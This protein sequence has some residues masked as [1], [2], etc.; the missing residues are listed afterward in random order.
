[1]AGSWLLTSVMAI[2]GLHLTEKHH[3][4]SASYAA[5]CLL[6]FLLAFYGGATQHRDARNDATR[7]AAV[8]SGIEKIE[9]SVKPPQGATPD[10][11]LA[12]AAAK[13]LQLQK[14]QSDA[15]ALL[16]KQ[17]QELAD[18][19]SRQDW[20]R[21]DSG[22]TESLASTLRATEPRPVAIRW[23]PN[24]A[25]AEALAAQLSSVFKDARWPVTDF[26]SLGIVIGGTS[27]IVGV[28]LQ[29][30]TDPTMERIAVAFVTILTRAHIAIRSPI[31]E[32]DNLPTSVRL[33]IGTKP[34]NPEAAEFEHIH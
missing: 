1:V 21:L 5:V 28:K 26:R 17:N 19:R 10:Q 23:A 13:L 16:S 29:I 18:L 30:K 24:D 31:E 3:V 6:V 4:R 8:Q 12:A 33:L 32:I 11:I 2:H 14:D 9:T 20:R 25:E 7:W 34:S 27:A 22:S 15:K